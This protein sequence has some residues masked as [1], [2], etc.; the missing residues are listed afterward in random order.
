MT[1]GLCKLQIIII[2]I[3]NVFICLF[4]LNTCQ[5]MG[6]ERV[7]RLPV[8]ERSFCAELLE[9]LEHFEQSDAPKGRPNTMNHYGVKC[10][11]LLAEL[12]SKVL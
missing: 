4:L 2:I 1:T 12:G 7:Y 11:L 8:F 6:A 10:R 9:E 3:M 5:S